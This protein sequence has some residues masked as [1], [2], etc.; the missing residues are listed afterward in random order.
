[1][2]LLRVFLSH[3]III[4]IFEN[5]MDFS[6]LSSWSVDKVLPQLYLES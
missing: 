4:I 5:F 2:E 3:N 6:D 1:M